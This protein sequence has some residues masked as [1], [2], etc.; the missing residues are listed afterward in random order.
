MIA[1][2]AYIISMLFIKQDIKKIL[3][4]KCKCAKSVF[5]NKFGYRI[6]MCLKNNRAKQ[7]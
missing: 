4:G 1:S 2:R 5:N 6:N 3:L 7:I